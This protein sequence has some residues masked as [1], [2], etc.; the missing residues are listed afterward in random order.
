MPIHKELP[1]PQYRAL[2]QVAQSSLSNYVSYSIYGERKTN[3]LTYKYPKPQE[4]RF[5][6]ATLD[7]M[8]VGRV[9]DEALTE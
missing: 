6:K 7:Q 4:E 9:V 1:D 5:S 2:P 3:L 8:F